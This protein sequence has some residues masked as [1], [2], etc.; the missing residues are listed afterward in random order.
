MGNA[1]LQ[2]TT[3]REVRFAYLAILKAHLLL[4]PG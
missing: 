1:G 3:D 4:V 2:F